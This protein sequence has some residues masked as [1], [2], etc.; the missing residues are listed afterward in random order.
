MAWLCLLVL[1]V[2]WASRW[3]PAQPKWLRAQRPSKTCAL[4]LLLSSPYREKN[5]QP[6]STA[7]TP[8]PCPYILGST[9]VEGKRGK[10]EGQGRSPAGMHLSQGLSLHQAELKSG[11]D[12]AESS[13][14]KARRPGFRWLH[15]LLPNAHSRERGHGHGHVPQTPF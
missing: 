11:N 3:W 8:A 14:G 10:P 1:F 4:P 5:T 15:Y 9:P 12:P 7:P 13:S 2:T 6:G